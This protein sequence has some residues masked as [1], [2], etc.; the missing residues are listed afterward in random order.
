[1]GNGQSDSSKF[2]YLDL[3]A[4]MGSAKHIGGRQATDILISESHIMPEHRVLD[5]GCGMGKTSCRLAKEV[6]CTVVG[7]DIMP[8]MIRESR[9]RARKMG[10]SDRVSFIR[11]NAK[12]LPLRPDSFDSVIVESVTVFVEDVAKALDEYYR[13]AKQGGCIGDNE[14]CVTRGSME[15]LKDRQKDLESIF[16]AFSS[17]TNKGVLTFEDW[18]DLFTARFGSV[19]AS[20][21]LIDVNVEMQAR[22]E[23]GTKSLLSQIKAM[24]LYATNPEAKRI[25]D[26][27]K[28][29]AMFK[30]QFGYG[31]FICKK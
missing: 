23:D 1:M 11:C 22:F 20:H 16:S 4:S 2:S 24:W 27:G 28:K 15:E 29:M 21:H 14:V 10:V 7:L 9:S 30:E 31:L 18:Q 17:K 19:K 26:E 12:S 8:Q 5:V 6:G 25:I 13:V 3:L